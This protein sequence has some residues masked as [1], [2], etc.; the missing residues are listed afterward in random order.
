MRDFQ[1]DFFLTSAGTGGSK[2]SQ[3]RVESRVAADGIPIGIILQP[4]PMAKSIL[5]RSIQII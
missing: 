2:F 1:L 4:F 3:Q 5:D